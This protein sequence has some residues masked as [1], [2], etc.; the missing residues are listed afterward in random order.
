ME[1]SNPVNQDKS[2]LGIH[3]DGDFLNIVHLT[4][5]ANGLQVRSIAAESLE[6]GII[7]D[8]LITD[9][10]VISQKIHLHNKILKRVKWCNHL[11]FLTKIWLCKQS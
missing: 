2:I 8:G 6:E 5:T 7:K 11:L 10:Q 4:Q 3:I 1:G 9:T